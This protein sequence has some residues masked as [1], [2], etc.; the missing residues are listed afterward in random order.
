[1]PETKTRWTAGV[2]DR[3][4]TGRCETLY[5]PK[6]RV[7][8]RTLVFRAQRCSRR[9]SAGT[10]WASSPPSGPLHPCVSTERDPRVPPSRSSRV[11]GCE[12]I[13]DSERVREASF[14]SAARSDGDRPGR[15]WIKVL[16]GAYKTRRQR[17][18]SSPN[19]R[20]YRTTGLR[21]TTLKRRFVADRTLTL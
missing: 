21:E 11:E 5:L 17:L 13:L 19:F 14:L 6:V 10:C 7:R 2:P 8:Y 20:P 3:T 4:S 12:E 16:D 1:M 18:P 9:H 15:E